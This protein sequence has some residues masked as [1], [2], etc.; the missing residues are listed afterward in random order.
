V[1]TSR[2]AEARE[3]IAGADVSAVPRSVCAG[4]PMK[5]L[6]TLALGHPTVIAAGSSQGLPGEIVVADR[7]PDAL[8]AGLVRALDADGSTGR[9]HVLTHCTWAVRAAAF[10][11]ILAR[12]V[13]DRPVPAQVRL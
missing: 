13:H 12:A 5:L 4:F 9:A 10:E 3:H 7:D 6:N 1:R 11:G 2:W 8:A